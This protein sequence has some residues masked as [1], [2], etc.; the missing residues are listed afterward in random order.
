M[1]KTKS[2]DGARS[3]E[4]K[5]RSQHRIDILS[6]LLATCRKLQRLKASPAARG[7]CG[8]V[9]ALLGEALANETSTSTRKKK[10]WHAS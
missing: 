4:D 7:A 9:A 6:T 5:E 1:A 10:P 8:D 2:S 3:P